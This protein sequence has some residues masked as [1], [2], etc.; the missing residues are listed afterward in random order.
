MYSTE[1]RLR[2]LSSW[3]PIALVFAIAG[4]SQ[5]PKPISTPAQQ[6]AGRTAASIQVRQREASQL[7]RMETTIQN[8][9][10][11]PPAIKAQTTAGLSRQIQSSQQSNGQ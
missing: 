8:N 6:V 3:L 11:V 10:N 1:L 2:A 4:C 9:P 5:A 7:Q